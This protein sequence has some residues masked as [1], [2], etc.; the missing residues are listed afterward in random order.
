M[1]VDNIPLGPSEDKDHTHKFTGLPRPTCMLQVSE[2]HH[3]YEIAWQVN[4]FRLA[5]QPFNILTVLINDGNRTL[6]TV[7][8]A[9]T[10]SAPA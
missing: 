5:S 9:P 8:A 6:T 7:T 4:L 2:I 10:H 3:S 1:G